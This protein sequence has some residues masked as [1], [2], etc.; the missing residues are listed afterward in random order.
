MSEKKQEASAE[1]R[2]RRVKFLKRAIKF[3]ILFL[4][5][6]P[7]IICIILGIRVSALK[8]DLEKKGESLDF[9]IEQLSEETAEKELLKQQ[10]AEASISDDSKES[11]QSTEAENNKKEAEPVALSKEELK[12]LELSLEELYDGYRKV[13]LTFD[14]GPSSLTDDYL[15]VLKKYDVK[16]T[17][18]VIKKEGIN[19][20]ELYRRITEEGHSLGMHS[21]SHVYSEIYKSEE[22]FVADT[23]ALRNY[24]YMITGVESNLYRFP[25]GSSNKVSKNMAS[26]AKILAKDNITYF[27]WNISARDSELPY[28]SKDEIVRNV[29][30]KLKDYD[31]AVILFHDTASKQATLEAL[32]EIIEYIQSLDNTVILPITEDTNPIQHLSV[33][34]NIDN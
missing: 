28:P 24:L 9:Y 14:D 20:E 16:A 18:F 8:R 30:S 10:L 2:K 22:A 34:H 15:D 26:F 13:Y 11:T 27:D 33:R 32:P 1:Y 23:N 3:S 21:T 4:I 6:V 31:S 5:F 25:G 7:I 19:N 17:F 12:G 29:A